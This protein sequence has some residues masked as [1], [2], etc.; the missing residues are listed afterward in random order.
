[1]TSC[2]G[3]R[4]L[5]APKDDRAIH[6]PPCTWVG[7]HDLILHMAA[8]THA[9]HRYGGHT[10]YTVSPGNVTRHYVAPTT[11]SILV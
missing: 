8:S 3:Y 5:V 11:P 2:Y 9:R 4:R 7:L 10:A 1:M 6:C